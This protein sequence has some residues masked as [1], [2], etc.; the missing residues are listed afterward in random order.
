MSVFM[1]DTNS[2]DSATSSMQTL[3]SQVSNLASSV[4]GY[5]T[6]CEDGFDF[7]SA[8]S[9]IANNLDACAIKIMNT[10]YVIDN[11]RNS[12]AKLQESLTFDEVLADFCSEETAEMVEKYNSETL[13]NAPTS[14][15]GT[16][17]TPKVSTSK[18][19]EEPASYTDTATTPATPVSSSEEVQRSK[20]AM[21]AGGV[22]GTIGA[23][24]I[25][26]TT[27]ESK[28]DSD[29]GG[30]SNKTES[31][32]QQEHKKDSDEEEKSNKTE[33]APRQE[34]KKDSDEEDSK[35][36]EPAP[37]QES[38]RDSDA[39]EN[40]NESEEEQQE[41]KKDSDESNSED[42]N[43]FVESERKYENATT[44]DSTEVERVAV[45]TVVE[46][47]LSEESKAFFS[48]NVITTDDGL[49]MHDNRYVIACDYRTGKVGDIIK[50]KRN[51][52]SVI[53]CV[54]GVETID[55]KYKNVVNFLVTDKGS[56]SAK[57]VE[58]CNS[59][60]GETK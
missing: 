3:S 14:T 5:D 17:S 45:S 7:G 55:P 20:G 22:I 54:V 56:V 11:V 60:L 33:S 41:Y 24:V 36:L 42:R 34:Y 52:G 46:E 38:K 6:S 50:I 19:E 15:G 27:G 35:E 37:Q 29:V 57:N 48:S 2:M 1:L 47:N 31:A 23:G 30:K 26:S 53:E 25:G 9:A 21:L 49:I 12:H 10:A 13:S 18:Q 40:S 44:I 8:K 28:V 43:H 58:F 16:V 32:P 59:V 4:E 39:E 51:D